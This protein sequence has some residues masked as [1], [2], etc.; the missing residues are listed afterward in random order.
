MKRLFLIALTLLLSL[1]LAGCFSSSSSSSNGTDTDNGDP[2]NGEIDNGVPDEDEDEDAEITEISGEAL[3]GANWATVGATAR[4]DDDRLVAAQTDGLVPVQGG[5]VQLIELN[6]NGEPVRTEGDP[7]EVVVLAEASISE[8]GNYSIALP[9][10]VAPGANLALRFQVPESDQYLRA[11]T[12]GA[13]VEISPV[14]EYVLRRLAEQRVRLSRL[15][16]DTLLNLTGQVRDNA[17]DFGATPESWAE[18]VIDEVDQDFSAAKDARDIDLIAGSWHLLDFNLYVGAW[19]DAPQEE[20]AAGT[21]LL[22]L[23]LSPSAEDPRDGDVTIIDDLF[24]FGS[25]RGEFVHTEI[26]VDSGLNEALPGIA[27]LGDTDPRLFVSAPA[28][29]H[30]DDDDG[31]LIFVWGPQALT[32]NPAGVLGEDTSLFAG[33][34]VRT[35]RIFTFDTQGNCVVDADNRTATRAEMQVNV[36]ARGDGRALSAAE[37]VTYGIVGLQVELPENDEQPLLLGRI[38]TFAFG[39]RINGEIGG[40]ARLDEWEVE[41]FEG[42]MEE[43]ALGSEFDI[44]LHDTGSGPLR[45]AFEGDDP[46]DG[47]DATVSEDG[48]LFSMVTLVGDEDEASPGLFLGVPLG[49]PSDDPIPTGRYA[50]Q[51][52]DAEFNEGGNVLVARYRGTIEIASNGNGG[53]LT[54]VELSERAAEVQGGALQWRQEEEAD[55]AFDISPVGTNGRIVVDAGDTVIEGYASADGDTVVLLRRYAGPSPEG[56]PEAGFGLWIGTRIDD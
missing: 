53:T 19:N 4:I 55:I 48:G 1:A 26:A 25:R 40:D 6:D 45:L 29:V 9:D 43:D 34:L 42:R 21:G 15:G 41:L 12:T 17:T 27:Q 49:S 56:E 14:S 13:E 3:I 50:W 7:G 32:F 44:T 20:L 38:G 52:V 47:L 54:L 30:C 11:A 33:S 10:D 23:D 5:T 51:G 22:T 16:T 18:T 8:T 28:E 46:Q 39:D 35:E 31:G 36:L 37:N 24:V 2:E